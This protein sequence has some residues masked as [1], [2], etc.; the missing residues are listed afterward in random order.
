MDSSYK[1]YVDILTQMSAEKKASINSS[2]TKKISIRLN[3]LLTSTLEIPKIIAE[4]KQLSTEG[5]RPYFVYSSENID[6]IAKDLLEKL[7]ETYN[8]SSFLSSKTPEG[9]VSVVRQ[10][11][12]RLHLDSSLLLLISMKSHL[13]RI[14]LVNS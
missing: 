8:K 4:I 13:N 14:L 12:P 7:K 2:R 11:N 5:F 1:T 3:N 10:L 6:G 9:V